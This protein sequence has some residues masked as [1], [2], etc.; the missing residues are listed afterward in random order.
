MSEKSISDKEC[1][2]VER[3][4]GR[5]ILGEEHSLV[6]SKYQFMSTLTAVELNALRESIRENGIINPIIIDEEKN[7]IDGHHRYQIFLELFSHGEYIELKT[8][9][10]SGLTEEQKKALAIELNIAGRAITTKQ[11]ALAM[12][13]EDRYKLVK[14]LLL[15]FPDKPMKWF[16]TQTGVSDKTVKKIKEE[17]W[18]PPIANKKPSKSKLEKTLATVEKISFE[19]MSQAELTSIIKALE[20]AIKKCSAAKTAEPASINK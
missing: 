18:T 12:S 9:I 20:A 17:N 16:E 14:N 13:K 19:G 3:K 4:P 1:S 2:E 15:E 7:I 11:K 6:G 5:F 10:K 8:E